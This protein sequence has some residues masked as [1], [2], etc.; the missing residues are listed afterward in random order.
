MNQTELQKFIPIFEDKIADNMATSRIPGT[1]V[2]LIEKGEIKYEAC[3]GTKDR[4]TN[5]P[6]TIN[7]VFGIG[8]C[9]KAF[10]AIAI[11]QLSEKGLLDIND[12]VSRHLD[13]TLGD[14]DKPITIKHLLS[15]SSGIPALDTAVKI[16]YFTDDEKDIPIIPMSS[17]DDIMRFINNAQDEVQFAP[18]EQFF[19]FNGGYDLLGFI[20]EDL[21]GM[22]YKDYITQNIFTP[23]EMKNSSFI[24]EKDF[25]ENPELAKGY[26]NKAKAILAIQRTIDNNLYAAGGITSNIPDLAKYVQAVMTQDKSLLQNKKSWDDLTAKHSYSD[27]FALSMPEAKS[28]GYGLGWVLLSDFHGKKVVRHGG[29]TANYTTQ[30]ILLPELEAGVILLSNAS[31]SPYF[32]HTTALLQAYL[33]V[34]PMKNN[35]AYKKEKHWKKLT[36]KYSTYKDIYQFEVSDKSGYLSVKILREENPFDFPIFPEN[37]DSECMNFYTYNFSDKE[38]ILFFENEENVFLKVDRCLFSKKK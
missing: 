20:I 4:S 24:D 15:H 35:Y 9:T 17:R 21:S 22:K 30:I 11:L 12:P 13:F 3:F 38:T 1:V 18:G 37:N 7:S 10:T 31:S 8:S 16:N 33:G 26:V 6:I 36:G 14:K 32:R 27:D 28:E 34:D 25:L 19:Y 2:A 5:E 29:A 23:L